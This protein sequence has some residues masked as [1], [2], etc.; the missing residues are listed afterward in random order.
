MSERNKPH[1]GR[2]MSGHHRIRATDVE[3]LTLDP[4]GRDFLQDDVR[5]GGAVADIG[6]G[7]GRHGERIER[8]V[9]E[10]AEN[11]KRVAR[12]RRAR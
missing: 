6:P 9:E 8:L 1:N 7:A 4:R 5:L 11:V 2:D 3:D 10:N 12:S